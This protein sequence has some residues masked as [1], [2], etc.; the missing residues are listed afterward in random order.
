MSLAGLPLPPTMSSRSP[1][2]R[3]EAP[4]L[5]ACAAA[6]KDTAAT[7]TTVARRQRALL[8]EVSSAP[9]ALGI[10]R[11]LLEPLDARAR[12]I[13]RGRHEDLELAVRQ[14]VAETGA[15][16]DDGRGLGQGQVSDRAVEDDGFGAG[17]RVRI[18]ELDPPACLARQPIEE[19]P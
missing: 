12:R 4:G 18:V 17:G 11:S 10:A 9:W 5:W 1:K 7:S 19:S 2:L 15:G 16:Q 13:L 8:I 3:S 6:T 14:A